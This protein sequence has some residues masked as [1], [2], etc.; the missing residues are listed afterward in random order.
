VGFRYHKGHVWFEPEFVLPPKMTQDEAAALIKRGDKAS[1][2]KV[3]EGHMWLAGDMTSRFLHMLK[4]DKRQVDNLG[5]DLLEEGFVA[6][7]DSGDPM[8]KSPRNI[9]AY[10]SAA[11]EKR[12][13]DYHDCDKL[14]FVPPRTQRDRIA[15]GKPPIVPPKIIPATD[16]AF[17]DEESNTSVLSRLE[18][19][20]Y[21]N[22][23]KKLEDAH[24][25]EIAD[26]LLEMRYK[27]TDSRTIAKAANVS[28]GTVEVSDALIYGEIDRPVP[29]QPTT[30][31]PR[32]QKV[33]AALA[34]P[35]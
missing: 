24:G 18:E 13:S 34:S 21:R 10:L 17:D 15:K 4:V 33:E 27:G 31:K 16:L 26:D 12:Q 28:R 32:V 25:Y 29:F 7:A 6:I 11:I 30:C 23:R 9:R 22:N 3:I 5:F 20:R 2:N 1:R 35:A 8:K 19:G 14:C